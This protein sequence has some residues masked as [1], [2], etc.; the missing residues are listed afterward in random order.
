V[1]TNDKR[2]PPLAVLWPTDARAR[3]EARNAILSCRDAFERAYRR[4]PPTPGERAVVVLLDLLS[5]ETTREPAGPRWL[6]SE[7]HGVGR[8]TRLP[9]DDVP[10][11]A[12]KQP[13]AA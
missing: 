12:A 13:A 2:P 1:L 8:D 3:D 10:N 7:A 9:G 6:G 4:A 5:D 11:A